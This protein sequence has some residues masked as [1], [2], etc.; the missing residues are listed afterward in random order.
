MRVAIRWAAIAPILLV[1][2]ALAFFW[3]RHVRKRV[4]AR[5]RRSSDETHVIS[6][7]ALEGR[8]QGRGRLEETAK[9]S[10]RPSE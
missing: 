10:G 1:R 2:H 3:S 9:K 6:V 7:A 5:R 4:R 8:R